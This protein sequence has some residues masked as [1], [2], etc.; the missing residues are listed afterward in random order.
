VQGE[1]RESDGKR[2]EPEN[3]IP[4]KSTTGLITNVT[5]NEAPLQ[6]IALSARLSASPTGRRDV[7]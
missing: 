6:C 5:W 3:P 1:E 2:R 4:N 7:H